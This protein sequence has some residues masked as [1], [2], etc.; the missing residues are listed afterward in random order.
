MFRSLFGSSSADADTLFGVSISNNFHRIRFVTITG[1]GSIADIR[2][3][4]LHLIGRPRY[5]EVYY[6]SDLSGQEGYTT[7][8]GP[9]IRDPLRLF[10]IPLPR[11]SLDLMLHRY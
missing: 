4:M 1:S 3:R 2:S 8:C 9:T 5:I 11:R 6:K 7:S 10:S